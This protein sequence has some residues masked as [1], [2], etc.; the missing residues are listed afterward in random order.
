MNGQI[1][2]C[3][4]D[5]AGCG[6][7]KKGECKGCGQ[8]QGKVWWAK[9]IGMDVCPVYAC[10]EN[11]KLANCGLCPDIPCKLWREMKDPSYTDEQHLAGI[12]DRVERLRGL[13]K[14]R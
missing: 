13:N 9:H 10:A 1:A 2:V 8:I 12:R 3:G 5:C 11:K 7:L 14:G 4:A 6:Y